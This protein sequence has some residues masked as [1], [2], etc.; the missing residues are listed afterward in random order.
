MSTHDVS[1]PETAFTA[2]TKLRCPRCRIGRLFPTSTFGFAGAFEM[3]RACPVCEL[4]YWPEPGFY[5]GAMFMSYILFSF[6]FLG[7][8][9]LLHWVFGM[10]LGG[11]MLLLCLV[12]GFGFVYIFRVSRSIWLQMNVKFDEEL[13]DRLLRQARQSR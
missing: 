4:D 11:S 7:L 13:S 8:V 2:V 9:I 6:P 5:Y 12:A 3:P 10:S 1:R